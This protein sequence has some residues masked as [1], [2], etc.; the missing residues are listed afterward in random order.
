VNSALVYNAIA[1]LDPVDMKIASEVVAD[2]QEQL[3]AIKEW[4]RIDLFSE[5]R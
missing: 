1:Q 5:F 2:I 4:P 3:N